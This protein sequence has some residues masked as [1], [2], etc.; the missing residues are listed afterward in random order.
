MYHILSHKTRQCLF[1][2]EPVSSARVGDFRQQRQQKIKT[3][4]NLT[5]GKT[6]A[7]AGVSTQR[8]W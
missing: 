2:P 8:A 1:W 5:T 6:Q 4:V 7:E 3:E